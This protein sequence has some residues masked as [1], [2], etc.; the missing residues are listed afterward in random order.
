[1]L[2]RKGKEG[3]AMYHL[4]MAIGFVFRKGELVWQSIRSCFGYGLWKPRKP[5]LNS[6]KWKNRKL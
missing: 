3:V 4:G 5:W 2:Y 6:E 1:M